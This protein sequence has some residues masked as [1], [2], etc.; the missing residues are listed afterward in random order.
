M[1]F[2]SIQFYIFRLLGDDMKK[3]KQ[4]KINYNYNINNFNYCF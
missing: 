3:K 4:R 1:I 2:N